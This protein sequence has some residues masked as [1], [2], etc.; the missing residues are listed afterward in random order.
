M[1]LYVGESVFESIFWA[2]LL[3]LTGHWRGN[4]VQQRLLVGHKG[5]MLELDYM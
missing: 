3:V 2:F 4:D 5:S 1:H